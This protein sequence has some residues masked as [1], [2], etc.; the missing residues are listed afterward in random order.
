M[1]SQRVK[2][3]LGH[4]TVSCCV[5][6][7]A[8]ILVFYI[9]YPTPL[10]KAN[11]VGHIFLM[12]LAIDVI[13][14]PLL[15]LLV[16]KVGKKSLKFDLIVIIILQISAFLYGIF[17]ISQGRPA[18]LVFYHD[19]FDQVTVVEISEKNKDQFKPEYK[20]PSILGPKFVAVEFATD[21][22]IRKKDTLLELSGTTLAMRPE[23]YLSL[24]DVRDQIKEKAINFELLYDFNASLEIDNILRKYPTATAWLPLK[25]N[26]NDMVVLINKEKGEVVKIV[27]LRPWK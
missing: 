3:F 9:W 5:A 6:I 11:E 2:Y 18:W 19:R 17:T 15:S 8:L 26:T 14:G 1:L 7:L 21:P 20:Y 12:L 16:Y 24:T 4:L 23:R 25:T 22:K 13:V 27:D 10:A